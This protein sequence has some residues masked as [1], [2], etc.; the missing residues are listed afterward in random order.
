MLGDVIV[1][2]LFWVT[3]NPHSYPLPHKLCQ[4][5]V[6]KRL[7]RKET[8]LRQ[9]RLAE[10]AAV[11]F[12]CDFSQSPASAKRLQFKVKPLPWGDFHKTAESRLGHQWQKSDTC[13]LLRE[14][15]VTFANAASGNPTACRL[16]AFEP[17][18][19]KTKSFNR[20]KR[21]HRWDSEKGFTPWPWLEM[22]RSKRVGETNVK[23]L[24]CSE[25]KGAAEKGAE[26]GSGESLWPFKKEGQTEDSVP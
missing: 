14:P 8:F 10:I 1:L 19:V 18:T 12:P 25:A 6:P 4:D 26:M 23:F 9:R 7:P 24:F 5:N 20:T 16:P 17:M 15:I 11:L 3:V 22:S 21:K 13:S 2:V